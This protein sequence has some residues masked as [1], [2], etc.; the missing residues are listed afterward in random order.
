MVSVSC[1]CWH[2]CFVVFGFIFICYFFG[3]GFVVF[4]FVFLLLFLFLIIVIV[5]CYY[6]CFYFYWC[7]CRL[8]FCFSVL[9]FLLFVFECVDEESLACSL[10]GG[11]NTCVCLQ[12]RESFVCAF[13][14]EKSLY[15]SVC[16]CGRRHVYAFIYLYMCV[17]V[18]QCLCL[19]LYPCVFVPSP[20]VYITRLLCMHTYDNKAHPQRTYHRHATL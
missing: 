5:C 3:V 11:K 4:G 12:E 15:L 7:F 19:F 9:L 13:V 14:R 8:C 16:L 17:H 6:F 20:V 1:C 18:Y 10:F 2:H